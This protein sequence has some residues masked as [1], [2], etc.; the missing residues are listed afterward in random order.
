MGE[1]FH[2]APDIPVIYL[3]GLTNESRENGFIAD[4]VHNA[5]YALARAV[6]LADGAGGELRPAAAAGEGEP[7]ADV[8][9]HIVARERVE[10][11]MDEN[12]LAELTELIACQDGLELGLADEDDLQKF[13]LVRLEVGKQPDLLEYLKSEI[14]RLVDDQN[15][16]AA[17]IDPG[18]EELV[19]LRHEV[20]MRLGLV[21]L[22][23]LGENGAQHLGF[24][25]AGIED[26]RGI[27][28]VHV[29]LLQQPPTEGGFAA[30]DLADEYNKALALAY[31]VEQVLQRFVVSRTEIKKFGVGRDVER[32]LRQ[33][34]EALIHGRVRS[35]RAAGKRH[36]KFSTP[37]RR[38]RI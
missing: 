2:G 34:I 19:D 3:V 15:D 17:G 27:V 23:Q 21:G 26:K 10:F 7:V 12:A 14:L 24:I 4:V 8:I 31:A 16:V 36:A 22:A 29:Q 37:R 11:V 18:K 6:N 28:V 13:L 25:E 30:A 1:V 35:M 33:L 20:V 9:L 5:G 38:P 32:H